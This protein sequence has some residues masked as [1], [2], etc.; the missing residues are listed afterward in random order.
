MQRRLQREDGTVPDRDQRARRTPEQGS[1]AHLSGG[2][3]RGLFDEELVPEE[4]TQVRLG[5]IIKDKYPE[6]NDEDHEAVRQHAVAA[7]NLTQQAKQF[8]LGGGN[9]GEQS[10]NTALV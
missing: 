6:L 1:H 10:A 2:F 9:N 3:E 8:S 5:K 7:L 4:L